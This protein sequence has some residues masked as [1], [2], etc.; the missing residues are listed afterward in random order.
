MTLA[1]L[2]LQTLQFGSMARSGETLFLRT[3]AAH[4]QVH[5]VHDLGPTNTTAETR[6]FNLLRLRPAWC[7]CATPRP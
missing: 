1:G 4:P 6:L 2:V 7:C 3:L 5:V